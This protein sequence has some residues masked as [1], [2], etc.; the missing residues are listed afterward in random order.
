MGGQISWLIPA[1]AIAVVI[2]LLTTRGRPRWDL[3][4]AQYLAW[5]GWIL[6]VGATFSMMRGVIHAYYTVA[7]APPIA[8]LVGLSLAA[9]WRHRGRPLIV[10][11]GAAEIAAGAAWSFV[12]LERSASFHPWLK[13]AILVLAGAAIAAAAVSLLWR[14]SALPLAL[15][16]S[17]VAVAALLA[18]PASFTAYT[19]ARP[20]LGSVVVAGPVADGGFDRRALVRPRPGRGYYGPTEAAQV[21]PALRDRLQ[22][23][24]AD[25]PVATIGAIP[26]A[27][28]QLGSGRAAL[29]IGG[30][31]GLDPAPTTEQ[32][33]EMVQRNQISYLYDYPGATKVA[34][35]S[36][37]SQAYGIYHWALRHCPV[38]VIDTT[39]F[40]DLARCH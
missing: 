28:F 35:L 19:V 16:A 31:N 3:E 18:G 36:P 13:Y 8:A 12:L 29:G 32:F 37:R 17:I 25:W 30:Y 26:A 24:R 9:V 5:A 40:F 22:A 20:T 1:A 34:L 21:S 7:L 39:R 23:S 14:R 27:Q 4:R 10:A 2:G 11:L 33:V 6:V 38:T 15:L